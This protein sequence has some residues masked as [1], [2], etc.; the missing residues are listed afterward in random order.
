MLWPDLQTELSS[1]GMNGILAVMAECPALLN[2]HT[3]K[4][5]NREECA[6]LREQLLKIV[7]SRKIDL[8]VLS[9]RWGIIP[10]ICRRLETEVCQFLSLTTSIMVGLSVSRMRC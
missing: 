8:V 7:Q 3:A 6:A 2:V 9:S 10:P 4:Y 5:K 1:V